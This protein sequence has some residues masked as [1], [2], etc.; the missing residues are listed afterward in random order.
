M[1]NSNNVQILQSFATSNNFSDYR[2]NNKSLLFDYNDTVIQLMTTGNMQFQ[3]SIHKN[4]TIE[5]DGESFNTKRDYSKL[6]DERIKDKFA[7]QIST[8]LVQIMAQNVRFSWSL[9]EEVLAWVKELIDAAQATCTMEK[10]L[11]EIKEQF[12][13]TIY[14][15]A[16]LLNIE[17]KVS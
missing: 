3:V 8:G 2:V 5:H 9:G 7:E 11:D 10:S 12:I 1:T 13:K 14:A 6:S 4:A 16:A 17:I 15:Q